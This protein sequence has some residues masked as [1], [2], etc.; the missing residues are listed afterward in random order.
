MYELTNGSLTLLMLRKLRTDCDV[1]IEINGG[2]LSLLELLGPGEP[3][4]EVGICKLELLSRSL[5]FSSGN[6]TIL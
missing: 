2:R 3:P 4:L 5:V 6:I 1:G